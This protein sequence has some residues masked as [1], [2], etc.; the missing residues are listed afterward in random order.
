MKV[1]TFAELPS[2]RGI[3]WSNFWALYFIWYLPDPL[4]LNKMGVKASG[5]M[6]VAKHIKALKGFVKPHIEGL[7]KAPYSGGSSKPLV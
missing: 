6:F 2:I 1:I 5:G 3:I 4:L 7:C